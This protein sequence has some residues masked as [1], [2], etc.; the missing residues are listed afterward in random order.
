MRALKALRRIFSG[1]RLPRDA[2]AV[3]G[4]S[5]IDKAA[6]PMR[7]SFK[8]RHHNFKLLLAGN[9]EALEGISRLETLA[10]GAEP[11][12]DNA[13]RAQISQVIT[14]AYRNIKRLEAVCEK[15]QP[16]LVER[17]MAIKDTLDSLLATRPPPTDGPLVKPLAQCTKADADLAGPKMARLGEVASVL[18]LPTPSGFVITAAAFAACMEQN[19]L[20]EEIRRR[21]QAHGH[22]LAERAQIAQSLQSLITATPLPA[23][24]ASAMKEAMA[25]LHQEEEATEG[26]P[27]RLAVRSSALGEDLA[28]AS[29]AGQFRSLVNVNP[30]SLEDAYR[31]IIASTYSLEAMSYRIQKGVP[32]EDAA[33]SVGVLSMVD[34]QAGGVAY[35]RDPLGK[36]GDAVLIYSCFGLPK[37]VVDGAD[38][39]DFF[40]MDR[41]D[42]AL[43]EQD[44]GAKT[45][46]T[47]CLAE[48]GVCK[49]VL[50]DGLAD[51]TSITPGMARQI[52][53]ASMR[54]ELHFGEAQDVEWAVDE[55]DQLILLQARPLQTYGRQ[56]VVAQDLQ[57]SVESDPREI[58]RGVTASPGAACGPVHLVRREADMLTMPPGAVLV[59]QRP[60]PRFAPALATAAALVA[61][62][63]GP[64]GHLASVAR[65]MGVPAIFGMVDAL[66]RLPQGEEVTVDASAMVVLK[67]R[68]EDHLAFMPETA[69]LMLGT[70]VHTLLT[71]ALPHIAKLTMLHPESPEFKASNC[72]TLHDIFRYCHERSLLAMF[73]FGKD[74]PF[75][76]RAAT[77]ITGGIRSQ[78]KMIDLTDAFQGRAGE[79]SKGDAQ[80]TIHLE[81]VASPPFQSFWKGMSAKT[82]DG[83]PAV[84]GKGMAA[85]FHEAMLNPGL[86]VSQ[87]S[88]YAVQNYFMVARDFVSGQSR[89]GF[90]FATVEA[91][92]GDRPREN[93]VSF[94]FKGGAA[95]EKRREARAVLVEMLLE[96]LGFRVRRVLDAVHARLDNEDDAFMHSRLVAVGYLTMHT[97]QLDMVMGEPGAV[98]RYRKQLSE[99]I[100]SIINPEETA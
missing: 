53:Q 16:A 71:Q 100:E 80:R 39:V 72:Q 4:E 37:Q 18:S 21:I 25:T 88:P 75:P 77:L 74:T 17:F 26:Q 84:R 98:A 48:E 95:N 61:E 46:R 7:Q 50:E 96:D 91:M 45:R 44:I 3:T 63:G 8:A 99:E 6:A 13:L 9:N 15:P 29:F 19:G 70:P 73:D 36:R 31:E 97:R 85:I 58:G 34:A 59:T 23:R 86:E 79:G 93:F 90:H 69:G 89:F 87:Q 76:D 65:E 30:D 81:D 24:V 20:G 52:A 60:L 57:A 51:R 62:E 5:A 92:V 83:P 55:K 49:E 14:L 2:G 28:G 1:S 66:A 41:H 43:L 11:F 38:A 82:W 40:A 68:A 78:F 94:Q 35:S 47:V 42:F 67:G 22:D 32:E 64:A 33:M 27:L 10:R 12:G 56:G 54:L